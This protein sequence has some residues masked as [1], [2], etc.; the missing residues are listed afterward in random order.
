MNLTQQERILLG[1]KALPCQPRKYPYGHEKR[2]PRLVCPDCG[3]EQ[4]PANGCSY[5]PHCGY[6]PCL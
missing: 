5:C 2:K 4:V 1:L 6:S 3:A